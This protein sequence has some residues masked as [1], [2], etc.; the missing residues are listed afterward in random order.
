[1]KGFDPPTKPEVIVGLL[2]IFIYLMGSL[3][4]KEEGSRPTP[5]LKHN[6]LSELGDKM[7]SEMGHSNPQIWETPYYH[8]ELDVIIEAEDQEYW[9]IEKLW[10]N[11]YRV[12][13]EDYNDEYQGHYEFDTED[14][15]GDTCALYEYART[16]NI[17]PR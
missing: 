1:M 17:R 6:N 2:F 9:E 3:K 5:C 13:R 11:Y 7:R 14:Y 15:I 10:G 8:H 12:R 16:H 4:V